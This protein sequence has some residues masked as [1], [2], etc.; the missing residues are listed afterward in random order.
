MIAFGLFDRLSVLP[1]VA[2][3][4]AFHPLSPL[5]GSSGEFLGQVKVTLHTFTIRTIKTKNRLGVTEVD[6]VGQLPMWGDAARIKV[7]DIDLQGLQLVI[8]LGQS[9]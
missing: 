9:G 6:V 5:G 3:H 1:T 2:A 7:T 4:F 8:L